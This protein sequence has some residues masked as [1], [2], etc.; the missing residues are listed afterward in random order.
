VVPVTNKTE[1]LNSIFLEKKQLFLMNE[2]DL[3]EINKLRIELYG[4]DRK[5]GTHII[6]YKELYGECLSD[7]STKATFTTA[8]LIAIGLGLFLGGAIVGIYVD[9][10]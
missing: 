5:D 9:S 7:H 4:E 8:G 10:N 6:G 1:V 3:R 2:D